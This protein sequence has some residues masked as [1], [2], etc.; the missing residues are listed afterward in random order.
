MS[1]AEF[2]KRF[3]SD[4]VRPQGFL[5]DALDNPNFPE[6][7]S[8]FELDAYLFR[9]GTNAKTREEAVWFWAEYEES[10]TAPD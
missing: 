10:G 8:R 6:I 2:L 4:A 9:Q 3:S 7:L 1:S 5:G